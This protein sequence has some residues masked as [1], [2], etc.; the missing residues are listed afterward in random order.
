MLDIGFKIRPKDAFAINI[1]SAIGGLLLFNYIGQGLVRSAYF[2]LDGGTPRA[3]FFVTAI[4]RAVAL[5]LLLALAICGALMKFG[6][7]SIASEAQ[8]MLIVILLTILSMM[9]ATLLL[10]LNW[11]ALKIVRLILAGGFIKLLVRTAGLT[12]LAHI[13]MIAAYMVVARMFVPE[14]DLID[15]FAISVV[16]MLAAALPI[17][18]SGWG[19]REC[20]AAYLFSALHYSSDAGVA[21]ALSIGMLSSIVLFANSLVAMK[22]SIRPTCD[23]KSTARFRLL[24]PRSSWVLSWILPT[25]VAALIGIQIILPTSSSAINVNLADIVAVL[26]GL[27]FLELLIVEGIKTKLWRAPMT[28]LS[29]IAMISVISVAFVHGILLY[30]LTDWALYNKFLGMIIIFSYLLS[31][32]LAT[33]V[34][35]KLGAHLLCRSFVICSGAAVLIELMLREFGSPEIIS[36]L[37]WNQSGFIGMVGNHDLL[38]F[39]MNIALAI[40]FSGH[41]LW[42]GRAGQF[43]Q[44]FILGLVLLGVFLSGSRAGLASAAIVLAIALALNGHPLR[45]YIDR[46]LTSIGF[47]L[48]LFV[49]FIPCL[50]GWDMLPD[51]GLWAHIE[52]DQMKSWVGGAYM[53][54]DHPVF[55]AG[56]GAFVL[57]Q[58][59]ATGTPLLIH[60]SYLWILAEMGVIGLG[61]FLI[62]PYGFFKHVQHK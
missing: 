48:A 3:A 54:M 18:F 1:N 51:S 22:L 23:S 36:S 50:G 8:S 9:A 55:G 34:S 47:A 7:I 60:N 19:V 42:K 59:K 26:G 52:A 43:G 46:L 45:R 37:S 27:T 13:A 21:M 56:L 44:D 28:G 30:G 17:S 11:R 32:A 24:I 10:G 38:A 12:T 20:S 16:T 41:A 49:I 15:L 14:A 29:I 4:E 35:G 6:S 62:V 33:T 58:I 40:G 31:G 5:I 53:W 61:C 57:G 2:T 25:I 39:Q